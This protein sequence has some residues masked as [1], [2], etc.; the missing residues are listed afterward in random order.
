MGQ[1]DR[2][3][4]MTYKTMMHFDEHQRL[5]YLE[6]MG[7]VS[8]TPRF[9]LVGAKTSAALMV[10]DSAPD[11]GDDSQVEQQLTP[12]MA[13]PHVHE[14]IPPA[15]E[16]I[17]EILGA[18]A[19]A[20]KNSIIPDPIPQVFESVK[21]NTAPPFSLN[22]WR[23]SAGLMVLDSRQTKQPLPTQS[24]L[25]NMLNAKGIANFSAAPEVLH[26][27]M[28]GL[29]ANSGTWEDAHEMVSAYVA[30][31]LQKQP[32]QYLWVMGE[33]AA[34]AL[35][36]L[37]NFRDKLGQSVNVDSLGLLA[38]LLPGLSDM[39]LEPNLK[40]IAWSAIRDLHVK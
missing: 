3:H 32:A 9:L 38:V 24:L 2:T 34:R 4:N 5:T 33:F 31:R 6:S 25:M 29:G 35:F 23:P 37:E 30:A 15:G 18:L 27:P 1:N 39:I 20:K 19:P 12:V 22:I 21:Q 36:P 10:L 8:Y 17:S 28:M 13:A 11:H 40:A 7:V 16:L 14:N 26:W